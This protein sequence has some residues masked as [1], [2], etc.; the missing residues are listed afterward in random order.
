[1][2]TYKVQKMSYVNVAKCSDALNK[3]SE[4]N[5]EVIYITTDGS[6][7]LVVVFR[8]KMG[9]PRQEGAKKKAPKKKAG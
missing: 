9:R 4:G 2:A 8:K 7:R 6:N 3:A 1:M 5:W